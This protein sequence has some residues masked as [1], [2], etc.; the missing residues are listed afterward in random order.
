MA[1]FPTSTSAA[2][3]PP[4]VARNSW[5]FRLRAMVW[6]MKWKTPHS[7][8]PRSHRWTAVA[9]TRASGPG[10]NP[11]TF[12]RSHQESS[13][14]KKGENRSQGRQRRPRREKLQLT[15][16]KDGGWVYTEVQNENSGL[17]VKSSGE[18]RLYNITAKL[19][20]NR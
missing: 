7:T 18:P 20:G 8:G 16:S 12:T 4:Y 11:G 19:N 10:P 13:L 2:P 1:I 15:G 9:I 3:N 6:P 17:N 5:C 14:L